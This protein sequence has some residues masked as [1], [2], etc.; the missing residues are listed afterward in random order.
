[1]K[2]KDG[3]QMVF[4]MGGRGERVA[5]LE[6]L[7]YRD[8]KGGFSEVSWEERKGHKGSPKEKEGEA[9]LGGV[10]T[11]LYRPRLSRGE[12]YHV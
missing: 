1:M 6:F 2:S 5:D 9:G 11:T 7:I 12:I 3:S 8:R 10:L 4:L